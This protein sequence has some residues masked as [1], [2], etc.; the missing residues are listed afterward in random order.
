MVDIAFSYDSLMKH[1]ERWQ[2]MQSITGAEDVNT[3]YT[4]TG[5]QEFIDHAVRLFYADRKQF[6]VLRDIVCDFLLMMPKLGLSPSSNH[7]LAAMVC[8]RKENVK[9]FRR[10]MDERL[11]GLP[12]DRVRFAGRVM[13]REK[14][15]DLLIDVMLSNL[16][17]PQILPSHL[18]FLDQYLTGFL[19]EDRKDQR[20]L[21]K[22]KIKDFPLRGKLEGRE[23]EILETLLKTI[24]E[25]D[26]FGNSELS[27]AAILSVISEPPKVALCISGQLRGYEATHSRMKDFFDS[28]GVDRF[29]HTWADVG[30]GMLVPD[31]ADRWFSGKLLQEFRSLCAENKLDGKAFLNR[32]PAFSGLV[33]KVD[34]DEVK[35]FYGAVDVVVEEDIALP[36]NHHRMFYKI[37][38]VHQLMKSTGNLYDIVIR[39]RP[40]LVF[41]A[42]PSEWA[43][44]FARV[45]KEK[46]VFVET[47]F[48]INRKNGW[49]G[50]QFAV[51]SM[52]AMDRYASVFPLS[53][54]VAARQVS[55]PIVHAHETL[56]YHMWSGGYLM[57][58]APITNGKLTEIALISSADAVAKISQGDKHDEV[59]RRL[60][61]AAKADE[62]AGN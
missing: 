30:R 54:V 35:A 41:N 55:S 27:V 9:H 21:V 62:K 53:N 23:R 25:R 44:I 32:Y 26:A 38:S 4:L 7:L 42:D 3:C 48:G 46:L 56:G 14:T 10:W 58:R 8:A 5:H 11:L 6:S 24:S 28:F 34:R 22:R 47:E 40:D 20:D 36:T 39:V 31:R 51:G 50:D 60:L 57:P 52:E 33:K 15:M 43:A 17:N 45:Q 18:F 49:V 29:V 61:A 13:K 19:P 16:G 1:F 2:V 59:H 12:I 37:W